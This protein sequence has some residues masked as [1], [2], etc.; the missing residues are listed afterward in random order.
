MSRRSPD[1]SLMDARTDPEKLV[2]RF[3]TKSPLQRHQVAYAIGAGRGE[4]RY[5]DASLTML[6]H[7]WDVRGK[8]WAGE[9]VVDARSQ[10]FG[11]H[12]TGYDVATRQWHAPGV[13]CEACHGPGRLHA[14]DGGKTKMLDLRS[15]PF[16]RQAMICGQCHSEETDSAKVHLCG[17]GDNPSLLSPK[18]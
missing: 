13:T 14:Q 4:Q 9:S 1:A 10:C 15:L 16:E 8:K 2:A 5:C 6:P 11:C 3:A 18:V 12:V 17:F 7:R